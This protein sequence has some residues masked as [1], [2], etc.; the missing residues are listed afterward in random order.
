MSAHTELNSNKIDP[1]SDSIKQMQETLKR[2]GIQLMVCWK[3]DAKKSIHG[4]L[5]GNIILIYDESEHDARATFI[6][7]IIEFKLKA[8]TEVYRTLID[9]LIESY[10]K[11]CYKRKEEF[12][13]DL[14]KILETIN[15]IKPEQLKH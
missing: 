13:E 7:E 2:L 11:L 12:I 15:E 1:I 10:G 4:E 8:V 5:K 6:H 9:S 14:P 3:P